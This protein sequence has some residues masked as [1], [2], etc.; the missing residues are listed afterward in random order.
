PRLATGVIAATGTLG[1]LIPPSIMLVILGDTM[2]LSVGDLFAGALFPGL[3]LGGL[4]LVLLILVAIFRPQ[5]MPGLA[6]RQHDSWLKA[7]GGLL[8]D[9]VA[10][11]ALILVVLG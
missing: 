7:M 11:M 2:R 1:I 8:A 9:L 10:P 4:Y 6:T 3:L 5:Y